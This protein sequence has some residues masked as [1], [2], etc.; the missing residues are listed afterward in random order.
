[1][2]SKGWFLVLLTVVGVGLSA[3]SSSSQG[4]ND[5][6]KASVVTT[7][8]EIVYAGYQDSLLKAQLLLIA[9]Q[10]FV[11][12]PS[13]ENLEAAK[14][15]W[16]VAR[17]PY[18]Q[19]EGF[20]FYEG[21]IDN[22]EGPEGRINSW[23]LDEAYI[24]YVEGNSSAGIIN[25]PSVSITKESLKA[26]NQ[27]SSDTNV[28]AGYHAIEFLL[29]GQDLSDGAGAGE[30][31][32]TDY[33]TSGGTATNQ[34]R[35]AAYLLAVTELLVDDLQTVVNEWAPGVEGN[36]RAEFE[37]LNPD[38]AI[39]KMIKGIATLAASELSQERMN[40][41]IEVNSKEFEHSCF[42]DTTDSD[43]EQNAKSIQ[44]VF[45]GTYTRT[46]GSLVS[47]PSL[48]SLIAQ[49]NEDVAKRCKSKINSGL[50]AIQAILSP[51]DQE[52]KASNGAGNLR[53]ATAV[54]TISEAGD[55]LVD[56]GAVLGLT[57]NTGI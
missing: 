25:D 7:Y 9:V 12:T 46:D 52:I 28:S 36:Y 40:A 31:P 32:Y 51:F 17:I 50:V 53:V 21:P 57:I 54:D 8:S 42:S 22:D 45:M 27:S 24:D 19:T 49:T 47:G 15:A 3:C 29:W 37:S 34:D 1:M 30:R 48:Y 26:L 35:R 39:T 43:L 2:K 10:T 16:I 56:A 44:N 23:P 14:Q 55:E 5:V 11:E 18:G 38:V 41:A 33:V 13:E 4:G 20:R 6:S